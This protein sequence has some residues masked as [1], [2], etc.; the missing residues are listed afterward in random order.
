MGFLEAKLVKTPIDSSTKLHPD[1]SNMFEDIACY[2]RLVGKLLYLT[3]T[4]PNIAFVTQKLSQFL[5]AP[6]KIHY[7]TA[8]SV[9]KYLKGS[10]SC[11]ILF[12]RDAQL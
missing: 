4:R 3:T 2:R 1:S 11:G 6:T 12:R 5:H 10:P 7:H 9:I 8:C